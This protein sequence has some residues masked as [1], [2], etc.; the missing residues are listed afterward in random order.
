MRHRSNKHQKKHINLR[1]QALVEFALLLP[2]LLVLIIGAM[3]LGRVFYFKIVLTN[4]A[5]EG[6]NTL[7]R[8]PADGAAGYTKTWSAISTEGDSSGVT[9]MYDEVDW[10]GTNCCEVGLPVV[11]T[12][13][14]DVDLIFDGFLNTMGIIDGPITISS[15]VT[16]VVLP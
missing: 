16:M 12:I 6:A 14:K 4:A 11:I 8:Y 7:S 5:R 2:L 9:I 15:S 3:D 13:D 1:A 10:T